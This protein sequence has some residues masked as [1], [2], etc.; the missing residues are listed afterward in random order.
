[1]ERAARDTSVLISNSGHWS[2][3]IT[4]STAGEK[5]HIDPERVYSLAELIDLAD[6]YAFFICLPIKSTL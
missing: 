1:M 3:E 4:Y 6:T 2:R 5:V